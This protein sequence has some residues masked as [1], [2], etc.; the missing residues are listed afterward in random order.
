MS[1]FHSVSL[2]NQNNSIE[3]MI[4]IKEMVTK[5]SVKPKSQNTAFCTA[6]DYSQARS[7]VILSQISDTARNAYCIVSDQDTYNSSFF[8]F[9]VVRAGIDQEERESSA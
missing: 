7:H 6:Q 5:F 2:P 9:I 1:R 8:S 4:K 3:R